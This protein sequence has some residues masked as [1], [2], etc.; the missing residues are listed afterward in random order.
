MIFCSPFKACP[1]ELVCDNVDEYNFGHPSRGI[2]VII[3]NETFENKAP[4]EGADVDRKNLILVLRRF[5]FTD[6]RY[7]QDLTAERIT[8]I[9]HKR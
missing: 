4:R 9:F 2:A 6:V 3:N 8:N 1:D 5:G 7:H